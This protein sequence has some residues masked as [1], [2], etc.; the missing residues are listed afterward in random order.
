MTKRANT[1][2]NLEVNESSEM[3]TQIR[4]DKKTRS[5][6]KGRGSVASVESST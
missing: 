1:Y 2:K 3:V 5:A 6:Q 4:R